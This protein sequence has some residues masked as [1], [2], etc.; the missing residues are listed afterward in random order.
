MAE[1]LV[2]FNGTRC[3]NFIFFLK[4][5]RQFEGNYDQFV[6]CA[7]RLDACNSI[8]IKSR[9]EK[10][11]AHGDFFGKL[12]FR[13]D[14]SNLEGTLH[15]TCE[16]LEMLCLGARFVLLEATLQKKVRCFFYV[17]NRRSKK[18]HVSIQSP[19]RYLLVWG[20]FTHPFPWQR[21]PWHSW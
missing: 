4:R 8:S 5:L 20:M 19:G 7:S 10:M 3:M 1:W 2:T 6:E 14:I 11:Q 21:T 18:G 13:I 9:L 12:H 16:C 17:Y 15:L